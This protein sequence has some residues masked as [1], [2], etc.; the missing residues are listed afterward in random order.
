MAKVDL[1]TFEDEVRVEVFRL[2]APIEHNPDAVAG[3]SRLTQGEDQALAR[4]V[5]VK[6]GKAWLFDAQFDRAVVAAAE[7]NRREYRLS[8]AVGDGGNRS[9][10]TLF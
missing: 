7:R 10:L 1:A 3:E 9:S 6:R 4:A 5:G 8:A 2:G